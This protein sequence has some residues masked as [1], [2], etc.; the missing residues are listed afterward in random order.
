MI[1]FFINPAQDKKIGRLYIFIVFDN[2][3][4]NHLRVVRLTKG[5]SGPEND[6]LDM[7]LLLYYP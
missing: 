1:V 4:L 7:M 5:V 3:E 2:F 6:L